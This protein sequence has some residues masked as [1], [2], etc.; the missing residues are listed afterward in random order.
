MLSLGY[1][2]NMTKICEKL[3]YK[4][5]TV[6]LC[7]KPLKKTPNLREI[8]TIWK[9]GHLAKA[10]VHAKAIALAKCSVWVKN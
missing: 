2:L 3:F 7:K 10:I 9:N 1:K 8:L 5:V 6:G 4:N